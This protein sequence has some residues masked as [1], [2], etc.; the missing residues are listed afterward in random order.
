MGILL[1]VLRVTDV[2]VEITLWRNFIRTLRALMRP[3][4]NFGVTLYSLYLIFASIGLEC[5]GGLINQTSV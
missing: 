3:F 2:L 4:F 1:R 5:F